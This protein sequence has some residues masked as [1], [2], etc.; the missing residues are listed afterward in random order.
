M[1]SVFSAIGR[2]WMRAGVG[3]AAALLLAGCASGGD[4]SN[5]LERRLTWI[6]HI[7]GG[8]LRRACAAGDASVRDLHRFVEFRDRAVQV[9]LYDLRPAGDGSGD[10]TLRAHALKAMI[11]VK[12]W[13]VT[14]D[15][16]E[17]WRG[18]VAESR[19]D[20]ATADAIR[21]DAR[22]GGLGAPPPAARRLASRSFFWLVSACLPDGEAGQRFAF[23]V[24]EW[25]EPGYR[26]RPFADLLHAAD[27]TGVPL[28]PLPA[29][30]TRRVNRPD[31][32]G[33][34]PGARQRS[35]VHYDLIVTDAGVTIGRS[36]PPR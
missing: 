15:I 18:Q 11:D 20:A 27:A 21:A 19:I 35:F 28:N 33:W 23:Q 1:R 34:E 7:S 13:R 31:P 3:A 22:A 6:D 8:D 10:A 24:W 25:P 14:D 29:E 32:K 12:R 5:P 17:P 26:T 4:V 30:A 2:G 36:Y 9:R 16:L